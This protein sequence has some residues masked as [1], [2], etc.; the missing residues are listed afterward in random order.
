[1]ERD[2]SEQTGRLPA[3]DPE[4][5][6]ENTYVR[7]IKKNPAQVSLHIT[8]PGPVTES[9]GAAIEAAAR[10][11]ALKSGRLEDL[12]PFDLLINGKAVPLK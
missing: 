6:D 3:R 7:V 5:V 12:P 1:M 8:Y 2:A 4:P 11:A 10:D 9:T